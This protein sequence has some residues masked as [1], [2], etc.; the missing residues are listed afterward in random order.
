MGHADVNTGIKTSV[1]VNELDCDL[2]CHVANR[3]NLL[4]ELS[5]VML[6]NMF[7]LYLDQRSLEVNTYGK[8]SSCPQPCGDGKYQ[9][10]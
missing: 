4:V 2:D 1:E 3:G 10:G 7:F 6:S 9:D 8:G 5:L